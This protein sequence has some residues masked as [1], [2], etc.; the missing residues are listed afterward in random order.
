MKSRNSGYSS[1]S[2]QNKQQ[3][4]S[5]LRKPILTA[6]AGFLEAKR[7]YDNGTEEVRRLLSRECDVIYEC[8]VCRNIF[9]SLTNFISHKRV[10]CRTAFTNLANHFNSN[11]F[12]DQDISTIIQ[13]E[14]EYVNNSTTKDNKSNENSSKDLSSIIE[15]LLKR[16][17][18]NRLLKLTDFYDQVNSKLTQ[19]EV[20][21]KKHVLQL[22]SV[23]NSSV[24]VY[25]TVKKDDN[26]NI[27]QEV[28]EVH[29]LLLN[30]KTVLGP[31]GKIIPTDTVIS[32]ELS[33]KELSS[34]SSLNGD[35]SCDVCHQKFSTEKTLKLHIQTK[36]ISSTY[37]YQCPTCSQTFMQ[38]GAVIRHLSNDH[39][40]SMRRIRL[41]R[42]AIYKRRV[43]IDEVQVKGP[44]RELAR[45]QTD[46]EKRDAENKSW[47]DNMDRFNNGSVCTY[48]GKTFERR[49]VLTTHLNNC[50]MKNKPSLPTRKTNENNATN[51]TESTRQTPPRNNLE[52]KERKN[53]DFDSSKFEQKFSFD[54]NQ[55]DLTINKRKRKRI[56]KY[57]P[58][59]VEPETDPLTDLFWKID[60]T[61]NL[62]IKTVTLDDLTKSSEKNESNTKSSKDLSYFC[63]ICEK[64]FDA[65]S[66]L[67]RHI[68]MF[69]YRRRKF[70]CKL[71]DY[72]AFRKYDVINHLNSTHSISG[73]KEI[74]LQY[75][76]VREEQKGQKNE[77][78]I[79]ADV[80]IAENGTFGNETNTNTQ[81]VEKKKRRSKLLKS[82]II[83]NEIERNLKGQQKF[84]RSSSNLSLSS[85]DDSLQSKR[86]IR[87]RVTPVNKDFV[88]DLSNLLKKD[89]ILSERDS[90]IALV[91]AKSQKRR[92]TTILVDETIQ[93]EE[94][95]I[96]NGDIVLTNTNPSIKDA[97]LIMAR[98]AVSSFS[99]CFNK[100]PEIPNE[101]PSILPRS[102]L[103]SRSDDGFLE[104]HFMKNENSG[105]ENNTSN[106][107]RRVSD[108]SSVRPSTKKRKLDILQSQFIKT[109][110]DDTYS[111]SSIELNL[112]GDKKLSDDK[113]ESSDGE[114][115]MVKCP[116]E[117][118]FQEYLNKLTEPVNKVLVP[119]VV[120]STPTVEL[121]TTPNKRI[122]LMQRLAE[123]KHKKSLLKSALEN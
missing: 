77:E 70:G 26:D 14:Q 3:D 44:S 111:T 51:K 96:S 121:A 15:R 1:D 53:I 105:E 94:S 113:S 65:L 73:E 22:D 81:V 21:R 91:P 98:L 85:N 90:S 50:P 112:N 97:A 72:R 42:D 38:P 39:K 80:I 122:T 87:K 31:D 117:K 48:C 34:M 83:E 89:M 10:Y 35:I 32:S 60:S 12:I 120:E 116:T 109:E 95:P 114:K 23:P 29:N 52:T 68:S 58:H 41:M 78:N 75:I 74:I 36:H 118:E 102:R 55:I 104:W 17:Q 47:M 69:H 88:Y 27:K 19:D 64:K 59:N 79:D 57:V 84:T 119:T 92:N 4:L 8:K 86:P 82:K 63:K 103:T 46:N 100:P 71:C 9:R 33:D 106:G 16:E 66:N 40:K 93:E 49:A 54:T 101:R 61:E 7:A 25:Q 115:I 110:S 24:A 11:G 6:L 30:N 107:T 99:A 43:R 2:E 123:N 67:R 56:P 76:V 45:L 18:A 37:V 108:D 62:A 5:V 28:T 13:A 20:L